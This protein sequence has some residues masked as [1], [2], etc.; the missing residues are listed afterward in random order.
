MDLGEIPSPPMQSPLDTDTPFRGQYDRHVYCKNITLPQTSFAGVKTEFLICTCKFNV[1]GSSY[2][3]PQMSPRVLRP[4]N[5]YLPKR[6]ITLI[7]IYTWHLKSC[8]Y[9]FR[10]SY[11][12][13][14]QGYWDKSSGDMSITLKDYFT[15]SC[16]KRKK[17]NLML[18]LGCFNNNNALVP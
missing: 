18:K 12:S 5:L 3:I 17:I 13:S 8:I 1:T 11:C 4:F 15:Q 16:S 10:E 7:E 14:Y 2:G 6:Y 9:C